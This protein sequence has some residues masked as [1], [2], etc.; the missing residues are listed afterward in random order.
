MRRRG[1]GRGK[2]KAFQPCWDCSRACGGCS[3][4]EYGRFEP[5]PGWTA[6]P[7]TVITCSTVKGNTYHYE[8]PT[9]DIKACPLFEADTDE[10]GRRIQRPEARR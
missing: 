2:V 3:W 6:V 9:Y 10:R 7:T 4:T 8:I 1:P 5:V